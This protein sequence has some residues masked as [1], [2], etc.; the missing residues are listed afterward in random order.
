MNNRQR[1]KLLAFPCTGCGI[2]HS[3][4]RP[5]DRARRLRIERILRRIERRH[6]V[7]WVGQF[8]M[9][10]KI[11][12]GPFIAAIHKMNAALKNAAYGFDLGIMTIPEFRK[13]TGFDIS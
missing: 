4:E 1:K 12:T 7:D 5:I 11:D 6:G 13:N 9:D 10:F 3:K 8:R 2:D